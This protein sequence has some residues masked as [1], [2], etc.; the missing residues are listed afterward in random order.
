MDS[1]AV[2][3]NALEQYY[4]DFK[5]QFLDSNG[6]IIPFAQAKDKVIEKFRD[7]QAQKEALKE[8]ISLRKGENQEAKDSTIYEGSD[9]DGA[10]FIN[11]L[12]QA[13]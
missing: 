7:S 12:S 11:L 5:N 4:K 6:Q 3:E 13:T 2:E 1:I 8:Y 10:D 9:E